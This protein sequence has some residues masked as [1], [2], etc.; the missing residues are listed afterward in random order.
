MPEKEKEKLSIIIIAIIIAGVLSACIFGNFFLIEASG[1]CGVVRFYEYT[2]GIF[3]LCLWAVGLLTG[4]FL[5]KKNKKNKTLYVVGF[6]I[7]AVINLAMLTAAVVLVY[8]ELAADFVFTETDSLIESVSQKGDALA[9][10]EL[11]KRKTVSAAPLLCEI[12]V[13]SSKDINLRHNAVRSLGLI[14]FSL[15]NRDR[16]Y[17]S[18]LMS[19]FKVLESSVENEKHLRVEAASSLSLFK[20]RRATEP[21]FACISKETDSYIKGGIIDAVSRNGDESAVPLLLELAEFYK[22]DDYLSYRIKKAIE[23]L[24]GVEK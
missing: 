24:K 8:T 5:I 2:I 21:L 22:D 12:A 13:D 6:G 9:A 7:L 14:G 1:H 3:G 19:L 11:G 17:E 15:Q 23:N 20:D 10:L 4:L 18:I 16:A